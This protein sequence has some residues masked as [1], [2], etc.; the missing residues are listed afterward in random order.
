MRIL[1]LLLLLISLGPIWSQEV[2]PIRT[3]VLINGRPTL[4]D[5]TPKGNITAIFQGVTDYFT[6]SA[7]HETLVAKASSIKEPSRGSLLAYEAETDPTP[8]YES[9]NSRS[10]LVGA[11]QYIGFSPRRALLLDNAVIQIRNIAK[12]YK[13]NDI[14]SIVMLSFHQGEYRSRALARNR[15]KAIKDLLG[16]YGMPAHLIKA[17]QARADGQTKTEYVQ[18]TFYK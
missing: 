3:I 11:T 8:T 4:V 14:G 9:D 18:M 1:S 6:S 2:N 10:V 16:A 15:A 5:V 7:S 12:S 13:E 17:E